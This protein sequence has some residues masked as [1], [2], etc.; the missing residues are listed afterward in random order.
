[1]VLSPCF[2]QKHKGIFLR[3]LLWEPVLTSGDKSHCMVRTYYNWVPLEFLTL[4]LAH[5]EPPEIQYSSGFPNQAL[6]PS[7]V[8]AYGSAPICL[9]SVCYLSVCLQSWEL[10]LAQVFLSL[11]YP[12]RVSFSVCSAFYLSG[13]SGNSKHPTRITR[14]QKSLLFLLNAGPNQHVVITKSN[15]CNEEYIP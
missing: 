14:N 11:M 2:C 13:W 6:V 4:R 12:R 9:N 7:L 5:T 8:S 1:M 15:L 10:L 3:Y